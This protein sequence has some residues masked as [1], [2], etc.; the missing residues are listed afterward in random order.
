VN[1]VPASHLAKAFEKLLTMS[2]GP[3]WSVVYDKEPDTQ[4][5]VF[6]STQKG[7]EDWKTWLDKTEPGNN[8]RVVKR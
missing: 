8:A 4:V 1:G 3:P 5:E 2:S 6:F 7:A